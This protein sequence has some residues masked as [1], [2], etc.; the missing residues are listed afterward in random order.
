[1]AEW[2]T[3]LV[4]KVKVRPETADAGAVQLGQEIGE[5]RLQVCAGDLQPE[6]ANRR[7]QGRPFTGAELTTWH[8]VSPPHGADRRRRVEQPFVSVPQGGASAAR[9]ELAT[10]EVRG[11]RRAAAA[12][13]EYQ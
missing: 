2:Y 13:L 8:G 4:G 6:V 3:P 1:G 7:G 12:R 9:S 5:D 11:T 10:R